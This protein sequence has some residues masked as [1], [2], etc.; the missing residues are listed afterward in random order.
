MVRDH[1]FYAGD[2]EKHT[3]FQLEVT[4]KRPAS[5]SDGAQK[6]ICWKRAEWLPH[7]IIET[8]YNNTPIDYDHVNML[9]EVESQCGY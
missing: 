4:S 3:H 6:V 2:N 7:S 5:L 1:V 8:T 9:H